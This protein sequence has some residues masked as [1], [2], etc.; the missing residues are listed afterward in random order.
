MPKRARDVVH[1]KRR[2]AGSSNELSFDVLEAKKYDADDASARGKRR[3]LGGFGQKGIGKKGRTAASVAK[4][5]ADAPTTLPQLYT[6]DVAQANKNIG[7]TS[8]PYQ[9]PSAEISRRKKKR[10]RHRV[11]VALAAIAVIGAV[12]VIAATELSHYLNDQEKGQAL[13]GNSLTE[14]QAADDAVVA[15][16]VLLEKSLEEYNE[17]KETEVAGQL[18]DAQDHLD[19]AYEQAKQASEMLFEQRKRETSEQALQAITARQEMIKQG[20]SL[21]EH[22]ANAQTASKNMVD[23][24]DLILEG[25]MLTTQ[26]ASL[27]ENTTT[28]NVNASMAKSEEAIDKFEEAQ[29]LIQ[30]AERVFPNDALHQYS[31]YVAKRIEGQKA[32]LESDAAIILMDREHAERYNETLYT[33]DTEAAEIAQGFPEDPAQPI[34]DSYYEASENFKEKYSKARSQATSADAYLRDYLGDTEK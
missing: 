13:L 34:V 9:D 2:T 26:A 15:M 4:T 16:D 11:A 7:L 31:D 27:V 8:L 22:R 12:G 5:D 25:D 3:F 19:V 24:W 10:T 30:Q 29:E 20:K 23:A 14:I 21:L 28:E 17:S 6:N 1:I 18:D 32:A 33:C